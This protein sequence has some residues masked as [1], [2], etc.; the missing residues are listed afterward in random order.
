MQF[1]QTHLVKNMELNQEKSITDYVKDMRTL[2]THLEKRDKEMETM[3]AN[4]DREIN[5]MQSKLSGL[6]ENMKIME[7]NHSNQVTAMKASYREEISSIQ[8]RLSTMD[9]E[10]AIMKFDYNNELTTM[11]ANHK[12]EIN[13]MQNCFIGMEAG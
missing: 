8:N 10:M 1:S 7:L 12:K 6:E 11:Q 9:E 4:H 13:Y 5:F 3:K 2:Y